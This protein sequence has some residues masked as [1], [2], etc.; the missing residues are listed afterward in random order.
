MARRKLYH[1]PIRA[2]LI[3]V[4]IDQVLVSITIEVLF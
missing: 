4:D 3:R 2:I 1:I